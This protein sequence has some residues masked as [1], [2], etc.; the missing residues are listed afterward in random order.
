MTDQ[1]ADG[2]IRFPEEGETR[3]VRYH[4][5]G[6]ESPATSVTSSIWRRRSVSDVEQSTSPEF[7]WVKDNAE[8]EAVVTLATM[9]VQALES[10]G[11]CAATLARAHLRL[12]EAVRRIV[13][14]WA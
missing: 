14:P 7:V 3:W 9:L 4:P 13:A 5:T 6:D 10:N 12:I 2:G 1:S 11:V 8:R